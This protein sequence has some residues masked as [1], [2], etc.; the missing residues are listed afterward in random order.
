[1][2]DRSPILVV[3]DDAELRQ[4]L[5]AT[6]ELAG[7]RALGVASVAAAIACLEAHAVGLVISDVQMEGMDGHAFLRLTRQRWPRIPFVLMTAYGTVERAVEA[8]REGAADYVTKP[9][10]AEVLIETAQRLAL[11][12]ATQE[13]P[14]V[15][16]DD[17]SRRVTNLALRVAASEVSVMISGESG[18]GKELYARLIHAKSRRR[19][20]PFVA[21]NCAAIPETMLESILF[22]YE[23]GA[24]TGA[25]Q[26]RPGK[27]EQANRGTL[28]LDEVTEM[29]LGLQSKLLRVLQEQEVERLGGTRTLPLDV[30]VLATTNRNLAQEVAAGRFREDLYF[31][32]NVFPL[33]IPSLR[34]RTADILPMARRFIADRAPGESVE[35]TP[36]AVERLL[37]HPWPGNVRELAN[38][39]QRALILRSGPRIGAD[40]LVFEG[41]ALG[42]SAVGESATGCALA[43]PPAAAAPL[44]EGDLRS[45]E[46]DLILRVLQSHNGCRKDAAAK[47]GISPRT[48]RYKLA[49]FKEQ[50][51]AVPR[52]SNG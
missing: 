10:D 31:R 23:K 1:M 6:L 41:S 4:A 8:I 33:R 43:T 27:F 35:L 39:V 47:L 38:V 11:P 34:Q 19:E 49:R 17:L 25:Y 26:S 40:C 30:R 2:H 9:F 32:L 15:I 51:I 3:E 42:E 12:D 14:L 36:D 29:D 7:H 44:L 20:A 16:A 48:L 18:T 28:L 13:G 52:A 45:R 50:G 37:E 46:K 24:F 22:G 5:C 21:I